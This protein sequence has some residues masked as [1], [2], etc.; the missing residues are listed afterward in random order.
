MAAI[1]RRKVDRAVV[2]EGRRM[3]PAPDPS[4][5][6]VEYEF[7]PPFPFFYG[8]IF[9]EEAKAEHNVEDSGVE[10][11]INKQHVFI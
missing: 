5:V 2:K 6:W 1:T 10:K 11:C 8:P 7:L 9:L 4:A 3:E